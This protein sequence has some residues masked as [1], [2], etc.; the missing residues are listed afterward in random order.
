MI[1]NKLTTKIVFD[2]INKIIIMYRIDGSR[3]IHKNRL[4]LFYNHSNCPII[5]GLKS[6][7]KKSQLV[8]HSEDNLNAMLDLAYLN[9]KTFKY[10]TTSLD[11]NYVKRTLYKRFEFMKKGTTIEE[12]LNVGVKPIRYIPKKLP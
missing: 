8:Y 10:Q 7:I 11:T 12:V 1:K 9:Y 5:S 2:K 4:Y 6:Q 3:I